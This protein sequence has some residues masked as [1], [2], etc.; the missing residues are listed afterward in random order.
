MGVDPVHGVPDGRLERQWSPAKPPGLGGVHPR[1]PPLQRP[2]DLLRQGTLKAEE[3]LD[4]VDQGKGVDDDPRH[5]D[6][7]RLRLGAAL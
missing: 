7:R 5:R 1:V 3:G 2:D 6:F 4:L